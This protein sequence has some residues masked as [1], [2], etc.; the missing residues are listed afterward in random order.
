M[1]CHIEISALSKVKVISFYNQ[2]IYIKMKE[3]IFTRILLYNCV[4]YIYVCMHICVYI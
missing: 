3:Y 2:F 1:C 4:I